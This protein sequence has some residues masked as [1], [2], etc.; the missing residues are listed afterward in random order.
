MATKWLIYAWIHEHTE[1]GRGVVSSCFSDQEINGNLPGIYRKISCRFQE[2]HSWFLKLSPGEK[3]T[4]F[5]GTCM[6]QALARC[7]DRQSIYI[8]NTL[9]IISQ[10]SSTTP[11]T[12]IVT[13][14]SWETNFS[15]FHKLPEM[16]RKEKCFS[17][18]A[19]KNVVLLHEEILDSYQFR[20]L[21]A[22]HKTRYE[23]TSTNGF[24]FVSPLPR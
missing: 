8:N 1:A 17:E 4:S 19:G 11:Q 13:V 24:I 21:G 9:K 18:T 23:T 7:E 15:Q 16:F 20:S 10:L 14:D 5:R 3:A 22:Y 6:E 12:N 2:Y